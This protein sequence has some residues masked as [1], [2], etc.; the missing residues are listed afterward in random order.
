M[1]TSS[2]IGSF[3]KRLRPG[4]RIDPARDWMLLLIL[5]T[6]I[7]AGGIVWNAWAFDTVAN[8][9]VLGSPAPKPQPVFKRSSLDSI[10]SIFS[11]RAAEEAKYETGTYRYADPSH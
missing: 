5:S 10:N 9:G 1:N 8:G 11:A 4:E 2:H 6:I 3:L 7:L